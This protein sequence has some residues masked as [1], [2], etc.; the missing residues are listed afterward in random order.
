MWLNLKLVHP[1]YELD[2]LRNVLT[3]LLLALILLPELCKIK[4]KMLKYP[5]CT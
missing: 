3:C 5:V 1:E 4:Y 2:V